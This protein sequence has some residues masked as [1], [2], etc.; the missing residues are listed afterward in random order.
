MEMHCGKKKD[1]LWEI[2]K[3]ILGNSEMHCEKKG[4]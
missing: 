3:W 2:G 4:K 1:A